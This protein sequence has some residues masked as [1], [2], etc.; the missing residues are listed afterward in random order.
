MRKTAK[1]NT[2]KDAT[3]TKKAPPH[4]TKNRLVHPKPLSMC[5]PDL[6]AAF[7]FNFVALL[8]LYDLVS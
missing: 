1:K 2:I 4:R 8:Y 6:L 5:A 3:P 7:F